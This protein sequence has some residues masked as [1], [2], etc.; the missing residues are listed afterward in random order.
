MKGRNNVS[1]K[2]DK[3]S[4]KSSDKMMNSKKNMISGS[5]TPV[6]NTGREM[7]VNNNMNS[8]KDCKDC[9]DCR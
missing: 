2:M 8:C 5:D 6:D 9:K 3:K 4:M 7:K 1:K